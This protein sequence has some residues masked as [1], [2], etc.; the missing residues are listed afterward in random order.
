MKA[1]AT[2][3]VYGDFKKKDIKVK[4]FPPSTT[5]QFAFLNTLREAGYDAELFSLNDVD[6]IFKE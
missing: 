3:C 1:V 2:I 5:K 4:T 6:L